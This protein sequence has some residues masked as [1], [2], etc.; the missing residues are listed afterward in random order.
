[1]KKLRS[2][3]GLTQPVFAKRVGLSV[4]AVANYEKD[5]EPNGEVLQRLASLAARHNLND[6]AKIFS[7][8]FSGQVQRSTTPRTAEEAAW[9]EENHRTHIGEVPSQRTD[10]GC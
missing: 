5:R 2:A 4:R 8:A 9:V 6:L 1:V 10:M 3:L 7:D